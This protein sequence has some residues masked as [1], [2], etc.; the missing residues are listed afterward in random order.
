MV[1]DAMKDIAR[2]PRARL[3]PS[4][5][6][7]TG[8]LFALKG[9]SFRTFYRWLKREYHH[10]FPRLTHPAAA[11]PG[12]PPGL[13]CPLSDQPHLPG[14]HRYLRYRL[15]HPAREVVVPKRWVARTSGGLGP[16]HSQY[17]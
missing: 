11:G 3:Y 14:H 8:L 6:V 4:E 2:H 15:I 7:T 10:L 5:L 12:D 1:D 9:T 16:E 13:V 17:P